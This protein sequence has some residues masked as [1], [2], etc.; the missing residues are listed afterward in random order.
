MG[1]FLF[2]AEFKPLSLLVFGLG[3]FCFLIMAFFINSVNYVA[4]VLFEPLEKDVDF[5]F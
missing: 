3:L 5:G 1:F 2:L 4:K